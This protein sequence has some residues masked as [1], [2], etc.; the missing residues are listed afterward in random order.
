MSSIGKGSGRDEE[1]IIE[2][3]ITDFPTKEI[4]KRKTKLLD[5]TNFIAGFLITSYVIFHFIILIAPALG[6]GYQ[7]DSSQIDKLDVI[8]YVVIGFYFGKKLV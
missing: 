7:V 1:G 6:G 8:V 2:S 4:E 5:A 3:I